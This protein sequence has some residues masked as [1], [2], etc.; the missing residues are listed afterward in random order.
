VLTARPGDWVFN[1]EERYVGDRADAD[2][3]TFERTENPDYLRLDLAARWHALKWLAPY[4]RIQN[5][6]DEEY[7]EVLGYPAPGRTLIGG[8]AVEF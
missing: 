6:T 5:A 8:V 3:A 2:A 1:L 7:E 4:A